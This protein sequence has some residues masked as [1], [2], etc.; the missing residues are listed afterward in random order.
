MERV[1]KG[2]IGLAV[3]GYLASM[4]GCAVEGVEKY[5]LEMKFRQDRVY[6]HSG[7]EENGRHLSYCAFGEIG[8]A[9]L[10]TVGAILTIKGRRDEQ[11]TGER[12]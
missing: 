5:Q 10:G 4:G 12:G 3:A 6:D 9:G 2:L 8:F 11:E 1:G 7:L